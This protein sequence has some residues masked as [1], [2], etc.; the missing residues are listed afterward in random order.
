MAPLTKNV[1]I[2]TVLPGEFRQFNVAMFAQGGARTLHNDQKAAEMEGL[3]RPIAVGTQVAGL[4]FRMMRN[5]F[6]AGWIVGGR[7]SLTFRRPVWSDDRATAHGIV[8]AKEAADGDIRIV[9]DVW[10]ER[11]DGEKTIVGQ[12]SGL[13]PR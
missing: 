5:C 13:V 2:G 6:E 10:V 11:G 1:P 4:I 8:I 12:C 7:A 3:P 9:C